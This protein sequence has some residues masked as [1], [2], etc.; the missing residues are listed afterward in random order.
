MKSA[1]PE[2]EEKGKKTKTVTV[3]LR[4]TESTKDLYDS[5]IELYKDSN[6]AKGDQ[7]ELAFRRILN[8]AKS[9]LVR[10][11]HPQLEPALKSID[12]TIAT[13]IKQVNGIVSGQDDCIENLKEDLEKA[14]AQKNQIRELTDKQIEDAK[15]KVMVAE[16]TSAE[17]EKTAA[18]AT[19]EAKAAREQADT[20]I[21]LA[22]EKD[23]TITGLAEKLAEAENKLSGYAELEKAEKNAQDRIKELEHT[24]A[25][26]K[27]DHEVKVRELKADMERKVSDAEKDAK[28]AVAEAVAEKERELRN[29][30]EQKLRE[31]DKENAR[32]QL[33]IEQFETK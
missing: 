31:A 26:L 20:A 3:G 11:T 1:N 4:T 23:K 17:A 5:T 16:Q 21:K 15:E 2:M 6:D 9:D 30:Y 32:L 22:S 33:K 29:Q 14:I 8:V 28:L 12:Q 27:K 18:Q 7:Q 25:D 10:A 24:L 13:L 19:K